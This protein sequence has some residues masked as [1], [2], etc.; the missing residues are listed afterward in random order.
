VRRRDCLRVGGRRRGQFERAYD[1]T[2]STLCIA[3]RD[4]VGWLGQRGFDRDL[5]ERAALVLSELA[6]NAVQA[7]PGMAYAVTVRQ[8]DERSAIVAVTSHTDYEQPPPRDQ[9]V[10]LSMFAPRGRGLMIVEKIA[11]D[12]AVALPDRET[13]VVMATLRSAV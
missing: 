5:Q 8:P 11:D 4:V 7:S 2:S 10:P 6:T 13:V 9:W 3:R 12:V 1:G